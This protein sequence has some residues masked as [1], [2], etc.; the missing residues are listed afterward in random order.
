MMMPVQTFA[1]DALPPMAN[2]LW[3][4]TIYLMC[5]GTVAVVLRKKQARL[6][7]AAWLSATVKFLIPFATFLRLGKWLA[8]FRRV[9]Q[10]QA[11]F[12]TVV[13]FVGRQFTPADGSA[14]HTA[15]GLHG[16]LPALACLLWMIGSALVLIHYWRRWKQVRVATAQGM[17]VC[18]GREAD[19]WSNALRSAAIRTPVRLL[20]FRGTLEPGIVGIHKPSLLWPTGMTGQLDDRQ[21][22]AIMLHEAWHLRRRDN[23]TSL[24]QMMVEVVFWFHPLAWWLGSRLI[25]ERERACDEAVMQ[26]G[27]DPRVYAESILR[28]SKFC[29]ESPLSCVSGVTGSDLKQR[30]V[31]IMT[32]KGKLNLSFGSKVF[33]SMLGFAVIAA[34][35]LAGVFSNHPVLAAAD[36]AVQ[37]DI[38][39]LQTST[40]RPSHAT[41]TTNLGLKFHNGDLTYSNVTVRQLILYAYDLKDYQVRNAP[42]W[43]GTERYDVAATWQPSKKAVASDVAA[44]PPPPP[45]PGSLVK[46]PLRPF[47][48]MVPMEHGQLES[49]I[50]SVLATRF[51]LQVTTESRNVPGFAIEAVPG[52]SRLP[53]AIAP[54]IADD[55]EQIFT[56]REYSKDGVTE[57]GTVG[58]LRNFADQISEK[59][60]APVADKTGLRGTYDVTVRWT[61]APHDTEAIRK[62][63]EQQLSLDLVSESTAV[64]MM[65]VVDVKPPT[66]D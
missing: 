34:P 58:P 64:Q 33:L 28:A 36:A 46:Q 9:P 8:H 39:P 66:L 21:L 23:F 16:W 59:I 63:L 26:C 7:H 44:P 25:G 51:G 6:R 27:S 55:G 2:H 10:Q 41:E 54:N 13:Q 37:S 38:A 14:N 17:P 24:L 57:V 56:V 3:Q 43:T 35:V 29:L 65:D 52:G 18:A 12:A 31:R 4:S 61:A 47:E 42:A 45:P 48:P 49:A 5:A 19:A 20:L 60:G 53:R 22:E 32:Y 15:H 62:A 30:M 50:K 1:R 11:G 40:I